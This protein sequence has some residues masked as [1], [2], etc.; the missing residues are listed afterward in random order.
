MPY[1]R[2]LIAAALSVAA[3][4]LLSIPQSYA[5]GPQSAPSLAVKEIAQGRQDKPVRVEVEA[6]NQVNVR[7]ITLPPGATTGKHCHH[8]QLIGVVKA[9]TLTHYAP[10]YPGGVHTYT[11]GD[12]ITEGSGYIHEGRNE[13]STDVVLWVTYVTPEGKPLAETNLDNCG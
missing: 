4:V 10:V 2:L 9:G 6:P 12:A 11:G 13:G 7:E 8:G 1:R 3:A 5:A